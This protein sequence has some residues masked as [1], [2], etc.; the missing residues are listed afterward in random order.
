VA[1]H[2]DVP[3]IPG[4]RAEGDAVAAERT[5]DDRAGD[6]QHRRQ[7]VEV[8]GIFR[9]LGAVAQQ[10]QRT[11]PPLDVVVAGH[12]KHRHVRPDPVH[13]RVGRLELAMAGPL[14]QVAG[15]H[16]GGG[17]QRRQKLLQRLDLVEV[18]I[19]AEVEIRQVSQDDRVPAHHH[20]TR[21]R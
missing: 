15:D 7:D 4:E 19:A 3:K 16:R 13:E 8:A 21:R 10:T 12:H 1:L 11:L 18:C 6:L 17:A 5:G 2:R 9:V 14:A 20:T